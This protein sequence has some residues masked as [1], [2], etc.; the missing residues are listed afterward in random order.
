MTVEGGSVLVIVG[1]NGA[2]KTTL[3]RLLATA[4]R[5]TRGRGAVFG[6][7]LAREADAVRRLAVMV[8]TGGGAYGALSGAENLAFAAAMAGVK[9]TRAD[10]A[11]LLERLGLA[12]AAE[13]PVRAYSQGMRRRLALARAWLQRPRLLLLDDP[14][15]GLDAEGAALVAAIVEEVRSAGGAAVLAAPSWER[16]NP[17]ADRVMLLEGGRRLD[18]GDPPRLRALAGGH[19]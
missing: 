1:P 3:L 12:A 2:G 11:G 4:L 17:L 9:T 10:V 5:P 15:G 16:G 6:R 18:A 8:G 13:R 7:D 19:A 14:F